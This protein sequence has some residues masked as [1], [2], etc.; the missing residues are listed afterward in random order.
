MTDVIIR[1]NGNVGHIT[2]NR[3]DA[4]N[5]LTYNMI[6]KIEKALISWKQNEKIKV[7]LVDANGDKAF[8]SGG[9]VSDLY[10]NGTNGNFE[11][12]KLFW[13]DEYRLNLLV[14]NYPKPYVVFMQGFTMGGGVGIS[15]HGSH[16]IVGDSSII[17]MPEC[18]IGLVP[19]VGGSYLLTRKSKKLGIY[20]GISGQHM[21]ADDAIFTDFADFNISEKYW[22]EIKLQLIKT[23]DTSI[24]FEFQRK[25]LKSCLKEN[26]QIIEK[27]F[28]Q[29]KLNLII[30]EME[31]DPFFSYSLKKIKNSSP[32]SVLTSFHMLQM[33]EISFS[34]KE[35]L[36]IEYRVTSRAQEFAD[37]QEGIRAMIIDKDKSP[38]WKY[39]NINQVPMKKVFDLL[40]PLSF[41]N[42]LKI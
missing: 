37:F 12:G 7:V 36:K 20:L 29:T 15:C 14:S 30:Q 24:L 17:A 27:V 40:E 25:N 42:E 3:P 38:L 9:D 8:C 16:R 26:L 39:P 1:Q 22:N 18:S 21:K 6:L 5:A 41:S 10:N 23:G 34:L 28:S 2:L 19:D 33:P 31:L 4:L 35:A 32:L 13:T 11:F